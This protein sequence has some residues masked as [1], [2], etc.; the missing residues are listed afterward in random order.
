M[1]L[2]KWSV[3]VFLW[4]GL[5]GGCAVRNIKP[6]ALRVVTQ[7]S[8]TAAHNNEIMRKVFTDSEKM[9]A[10]LNYLRLL[11]P[12]LP[13]KY[14]ADTFRSDAYEIIVHY[15]DGDQTTYHQIYHDYLKKDTGAWLRIDP[16]QASKLLPLLESMSTDAL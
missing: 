11:D 10:V 13:S 7:V 12:Y 16:A 14:E 8:V 9:E 3:F 5:L 6:G 2:R 15:S 1:K 4:C